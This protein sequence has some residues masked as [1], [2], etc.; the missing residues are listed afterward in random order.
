MSPL[1]SQGRVLSHALSSRFATSSTAARFVLTELAEFQLFR[2]LAVPGGIPALHVFTRSDVAALPVGGPGPPGAQVI[3]YR[4]VGAD[5]Y[6]FHMPGL[7]A[8][9]A[10][11]RCA[12]GPQAD[13]PVYIAGF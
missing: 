2:V 6:T 13:P 11:G 3:R 10:T 8:I 4:L 1:C 9:V 7:E 5:V 12:Q